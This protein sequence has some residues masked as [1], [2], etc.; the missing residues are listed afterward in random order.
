M[1]SI[2]DVAK[3]A[4]VSITTVSRAFNDQG[5]LSPETREKILNVAE[6][7]NYAPKKYQKLGH[8]LVKNSNIGVIISFRS[9][10]WCNVI[11]DG[12]CDFLETEGILPVFVNTNEIP[13]REITC[14]DKLKNS[15]SGM[16]VYSSTE[17]NKYCTDFLIDVSKNIPIVTIVRNTNLYNIDSISID[18]Y[19]PTYN[20]LSELIKNGHKH[21]A[22]INGPMVIKPSMER[23]N[24]YTQVLK[25]NGIPLRNEYIFY[26][27]FNEQKA[28]EIAGEILKIAPKVTAVFA[29]N[30]VIAQGCLK[31][32]MNHNIK[33]PD[34]MAFVCSGDT[35]AFSLPGSQIS[36]IA[37]PDY[38]IGYKGASLLLDRIKNPIGKK[39]HNPQRIILEPKIILRGS[40][41]Y[42]QTRN[43]E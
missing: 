13:Y 4:G 36:V 31:G 7:L 23:F 32:F 25:D 19:R 15:V 18:T 6:K 39:N 38:E 8:K 22:I 41:R 9:C 28:S 42:P 5:G 3:L 11:M 34:D 35:F 14:I 21:I 29:S 12:I 1:Y 33:I 10:P 27:D 17:F 37:D 20:L 16:I 30:S 26:S 2:H 40:E 24:A 43:A